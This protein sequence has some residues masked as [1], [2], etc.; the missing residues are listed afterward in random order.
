MHTV[1]QVVLFGRIG[2]DPEH[3]VTPSGKEVTRLSLAT[4]RS[5]RDGDTWQQKTDWHRVVA[6]ERLARQAVECLK[7]GDQVAVVGQLRPNHFTDRE[8]QNRTVV[9]VTASRLCF[10]PNRQPPRSISY[11]A[12]PPEGRRRHQAHS[13]T[14]S[15]T[16]AIQTVD[17]DEN[18]P[19][20][21]PS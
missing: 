21:T 3:R 18:Q 5:V 13:E 8:G 10:V 7:K 6:F 14:G 20:S 2:S 17:S 11:E 4:H 9:E 12:D 15:T 19:N 1:N 16:G